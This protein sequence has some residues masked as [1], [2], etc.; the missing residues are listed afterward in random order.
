MYRIP[1]ALVVLLVLCAP[2][3]LAVVIE[4]PL[5]D[6]NGTYGADRTVPLQLP[7]APSVIHGASFR[8]TGTTQVGTLICY[9]IETGNYDVPAVWASE[10]FIYVHDG[11]YLPSWYMDKTM[12]VSGPFSHQDTA[13]PLLGATWDFLLDGVGVVT[14]HGGG[15]GYTS[16]AATSATPTVTV[17]EAVLIIDAEF[18]IAIESSTWGRIKALYR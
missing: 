18:P 1:A 7:V 5:P 14:F 10:A 9:N 8:V 4:I 17:T 3:A 16:C 6:L 12:V 2:P 11:G 15:T 13:R